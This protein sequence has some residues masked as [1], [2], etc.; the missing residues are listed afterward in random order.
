M[1]LNFI[2]I[3]L[4]FLNSL[5][6]SNFSTAQTKSYDTERKNDINALYQKLEE[7]Y[8][9]NGD[10]P[11]ADAVK[12]KYETIFPGIDVEAFIDPNDKRINES[13]DY[14]YTPANCT[15]LG[16]AKYTLSAQLESEEPY[17][18]QSLN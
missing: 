9:E 16:C 4:S 17:T 8:N 6:F 5:V 7:Y 12:N 15:A 10:Y 1:G 14:T 13:G 3:I 2:F 11:T 18:K